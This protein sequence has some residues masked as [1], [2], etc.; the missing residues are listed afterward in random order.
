MLPLPLTQALL[1]ATSKTL[2]TTTTTTPP[3]QRERAC[4]NPW[5]RTDRF[6]TERTTRCRPLRICEQEKHHHHGRV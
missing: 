6:Q 3:P 4:S 5:C 2:T 1:R